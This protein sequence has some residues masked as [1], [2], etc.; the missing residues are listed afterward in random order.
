M[1]YEAEFYNSND[2]DY[3][4]RN[5]ET[6]DDIKTNDKRYRKFK[7]VVNNVFNGKYYKTVQIELYISGDTGSTIRDAVTG[8]YSEHLVGSKEE[9]LYFK[10]HVEMTVSGPN[11]GSAFY[12][13]PEE[14]EKHQFVILPPLIKQNWY[15]KN[16]HAR[17][18]IS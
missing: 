11:Q 7:K 14:Y 9:D 6:L 2:D 17:K 13:S 16:F 12:S 18:C 15:N 3:T 10:V 5:K 1:Y 8:R 4:E